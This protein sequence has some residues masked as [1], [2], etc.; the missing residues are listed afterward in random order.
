[1]NGDDR[2][3]PVYK[4]IIAGTIVFIVGLFIFSVIFQAF[5]VFQEVQQALIVT[6]N[7]SSTDPTVLIL[8][9]IPWGL[10]LFYISLVGTVIY[11]LLK[12]SRR[13]RPPPIFWR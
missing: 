10:G 7:F 5:L 2:D 4:V 1:M 12:G 6:G 9:V 13:E 8:S 11:F 3:I